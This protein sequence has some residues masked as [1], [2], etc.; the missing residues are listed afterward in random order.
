MTNNIKSDKFL[1][2]KSKKNKDFSIL[3]T[4]IHSHLIPGIDDGVKTLEEAAFCIKEMKNLGFSKIITTPHVN[5]DY[6]YNTTDEI[7]DGLE[8]LNNYLKKENIDILVEA[9]AEYYLNNDLIENIENNNLITFGDNYILFE[10][11][12]F[13]PVKIL[14]EAIFKL[15][16]KGYKP[17]LAHPERYNYWFDN[18]DVLK[19]LKN[20][21]V[22]FQ[23][24]TLSLSGA[25]SEGAKQM[26]EKLI[27]NN[28]IEFI[29]S[30]A[31]NEHYVNGLKPILS[32]KHLKKL[33]ASDNLLNNTL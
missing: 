16:T 8:I 12:Y 11:S 18:L 9:S 19:N 6:F 5:I 21:G 7:K 27:K 17:V 31:H 3:K 20:K 28:M 2:S 29:G 32:N 22:Y 13:N 33:I 30:D 26:A 25:F 14:D 1:M 10:L 24:N 23:M 4:D 15:Q